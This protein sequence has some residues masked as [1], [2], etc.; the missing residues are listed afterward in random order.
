MNAQ[1]KNSKDHYK[2]T[3]TVEP[4]KSRSLIDAAVK[5]GAERVFLAKGRGVLHKQKLGVIPLPGISPSFDILTLI[6]TKEH[7]ELLMNTLVHVGRLHYFGAGA[8][9]ATK[10]HDTWYNG[11]APFSASGTAAA[12][13]QYEFQKDLIAVNCIC[14]LDHAEEIAHSAMLA[15]SPSPTITFGYGHGIRDRLGFFLQ[16]TINPKKEFIGL[17]VGSAEAERIFEDMVDSGHLD[18]PA[19]GFI[20]TNPVEMGLINTVSFQATSQYPATMEQII[21]AIDQMQGNTNW[22][23]SGSVQT[24]SVKKRKKLLNLVSLNCVV[25]RGFGDECSM[26]AME[27]GASGT[28]TT[29]ANAFP[30]EKRE[31]RHLE[32]SDERELISLTIGES[33]VAPIVDAI[34]S[35]KE[36]ADSPVVM[37]TFPAPVAL[38]YLK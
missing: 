9:Y 20:Y 38:T 32:G 7:L 26:A 2:V 33:Q 10:I 29:Y 15:G 19:M 5:L 30:I 14:Q 25:P 18:Q 28:S 27:A 4:E 31:S 34:S 21:K 37:Y 12:P 17:V 1:Y 24:S 3:V 6:V 36:L 22:R 35:M 8:I 13:A 16:L 11:P 23:S